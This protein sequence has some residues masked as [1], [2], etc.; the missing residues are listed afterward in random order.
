VRTLPLISKDSLVLTEKAVE[1][2]QIQ[3][4]GKKRGGRERREEVTLI[5]HI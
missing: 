4:L 1:E 5:W 2:Q 3:E